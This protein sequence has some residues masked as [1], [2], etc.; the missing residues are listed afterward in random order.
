M[1]LF[2]AL[3][4]SGLIQKIRQATGS[5][6]ST[7]TKYGENISKHRSLMSLYDLH[8]QIG[9]Q[10]YIAPNSTVIGEVTI[11]NETTVWYNSVIR[12]DVNAVQI[13]N[14]VSIGENVVIHTAGSLPTGQPASVDIGHYVIIGSKSTIYS[15]TIQDEVV[16]GQGCVILEGA[17]IEK[18]AM[19]AA[20]SVVPPGRLIPA[21]TL[22]AGNPCTFVRNLTKSELATNID[23]AK[24]QLHLAQ[25]HRYEYLPYNSAYLQKSNSE[26]DLNPTKYDDVTINYN[27]G[28]EERAQENP[29]KY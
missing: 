4:K 19:I 25:Q 6:I 7:A 12:G 1:K 16:I 17:R 11:G 13:G 26:E 21:G 15:C 9:Y 27:F 14:N 29:L 8:P 22:W 24:K 2:R 18:G 23:H 28:D 5:E 20:N 3:T 10:S